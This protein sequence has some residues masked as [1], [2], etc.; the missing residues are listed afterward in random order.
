MRN[1]REI[2]N[3]VR[4]L[5]LLDVV[6]LLGGAQDSED[7]QRWDFENCSVWLGKGQDSQRFY[8]H[9]AGK[10]GGGAIDLV[11]YVEGCD[12]KHAVSMLS[13][14]IGQ[15]DFTQR[16]TAVH[17][18][19]LKSNFIPPKRVEKHRDRVLA[20]LIE[21][22]KLSKKIVEPLIQKGDIYADSRRNAVFLCHGIDGAVS[23]A[24]LRGTCSQPFK[25]MAPGSKR[26]TGFF[27]IS[28]ENPTELIIVESAIDAISYKTLFPA[29]NA[30]IVS[31]AGVLPE[32][33]A[34]AIW[35]EKYG[36]EDIAIAYDNDE[37]GNIAADQLMS[38]FSATSYTL[39]RR[40]PYVHK[41]WNEI[42]QHEASDLICTSQG[43]MG[44]GDIV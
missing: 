18:P 3:H 12:F 38:S 35:A 22:R 41:D 29:T 1:L 11:M 7:K 14:L 24:E 16:K 28:H 6:N 39:H 27:T 25:G 43:E 34:L 23:G 33:Q 26:S 31:T 19:V 37:P 44:E 42:V 30:V 4:S 32:C 36:V 21:Q 13:G 9:H 5:P 15:S 8:D 20:Y 10:G 2:A 40:E 17:Q